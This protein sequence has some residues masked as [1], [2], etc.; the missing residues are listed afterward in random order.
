MPAHPGHRDRNIPAYAVQ[1]FPVGKFLYFKCLFIEA[2]SDQPFPR[3][4]CFRPAFQAGIEFFAAAAGRKL[5]VFQK[6]S[7]SKQMAVRV[8]KARIDSRAVEINDLSIRC[9]LRKDLIR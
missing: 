8:N 4:E 3:H 7:E 1:P 5:H 2:A 9:D 6:P